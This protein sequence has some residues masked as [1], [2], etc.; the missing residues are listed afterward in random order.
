[1]VDVYIFLLYSARNCCFCFSRQHGAFSSWSHQMYVN[2]QMI[3]RNKLLLPS[4]V[5]QRRSCVVCGLFRFRDCSGCRCC[6]RGQ[7][8][9]LLALWIAVF[10]STTAAVH[11][12]VLPTATAAGG[13]AGV[14]PV[15]V[16]KSS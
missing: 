2:V 5:V 10:M 3:F 4:M 6:C 11:V 15:V 16:N 7:L 8:L 9:L 14:A 12:H 13:P 1:M